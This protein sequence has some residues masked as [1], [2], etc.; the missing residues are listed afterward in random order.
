MIEK[1]LDEPYWNEQEGFLELYSNVFNTLVP[2]PKYVSVPLEK[3]EESRILSE[4]IVYYLNLSLV[5]YNLTLPRKDRVITFLSPL[6]TSEL[7]QVKEL[8]IKV[9][10]RGLTLGAPDL[11]PLDVRREVSL[12]IKPLNNIQDLLDIMVDQAII[13]EAEIWRR[14]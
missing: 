12:Y 4:F 7:D 9:I 2:M 3:D 8:I 10:S 5:G 13:N 6:I 14:S 11:T 1:L